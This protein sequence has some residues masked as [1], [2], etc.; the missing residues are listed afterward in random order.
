MR[1]IFI[2]HGDPDYSIDNLTE[3]GKREVSFLTERICKWKNIT[4]F[5][6]S[7]LG[8]ARATGEM[9]LKKLEREAKVCDW[10]KEFYYPVKLPQNYPDSEKIGQ[11]HICWD[12]PPEF[13]TENQDFFDKNKWSNVDFLKNAEIDKHF[14]EVSNGID[15]ILSEYGYFRNK[16]GFYDVKNP[17]PNH[18]WSEQI[19]QYHLK[20]VKNDYP[21]EK[22]L[23]FFCHLGVMFA[24]ISHLIGISPLVLWHGFFVAPTSI[25]ILNTEERKKGQA[26]F[27]VERLGDTNHLTNN[28]EPISSSGYFADIFSENENRKNFN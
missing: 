10:L 16:Q 25:T 19:S 1:L 3:K 20:S 22:T 13:L 21:E 6:T 9:A 14:Q 17:V 15:E 12:F 11:E 24:I 8:R 28:G 4:E 18:N 7:P 5:Y 26:W 23:V 27:R 2:R